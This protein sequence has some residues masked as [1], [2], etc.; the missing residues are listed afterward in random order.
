[1]GTIGRQYQSCFWRLAVIIKAHGELMEGSVIDEVALGA[2]GKYGAI[3]IAAA[4]HGRPVQGRAVAGHYQ[5]REDRMGSI[6][7]AGTGEVMKIAIILAMDIHFEHDA[8]PV[9]A[10]ILCCAVQKTV[11]VEH[12]VSL[13][14]CPI[15][16]IV[17]EVP[18]CG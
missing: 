13:G 7:I 6:V 16:R 10:A 14:I 3:V 8:V 18:D 9:L 1:H 4:E 2:D 17:A 15:I 12:E 11:R 5:A